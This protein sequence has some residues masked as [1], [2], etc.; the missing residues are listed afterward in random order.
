MLI[1]PPIQE[2]IKERSELV[3][4]HHKAITLWVIAL[5]VP[6]KICNVVHPILEFWLVLEKLKEVSPPPL[7][8]LHISVRTHTFNQLFS[9]ALEVVSNCERTLHVAVH[10]ELLAWM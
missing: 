4:V 5:L 10:V 1:G 2:A 8:G 6:E 3:R 9:S 7:Q